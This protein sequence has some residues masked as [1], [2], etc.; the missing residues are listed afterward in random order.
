MSLFTI[1]LL[2]RISSFSLLFIILGIV[3]VVAT[4]VCLVAQIDESKEE[5]V[6]RWQRRARLAAASAL[7]FAILTTLLPGRSALAVIFAGHWATNSEEASKLPANVV[8]TMN[9]FMEEYNKDDSEQQ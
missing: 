5:V 9:K 1:Y 3:C 2:T 6:V 8:K 7:T 4:I